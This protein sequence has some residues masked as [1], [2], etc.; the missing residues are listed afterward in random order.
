MAKAKVELMGCLTYTV[1]GRKFTRGQPQIITNAAEI[2]LFQQQP[3]FGVTMLDEPLKE[4]AAEVED[5]G[6]VTYS[7]DK[8]K[9]MTKPELLD[10]AAE[11]AVF[12]EGNE[13]K[14]KMID[15]ILKAQDEAKE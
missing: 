4:K 6:L 10:V 15:Q 3:E 7:E 2:K 9:S 5:P 8:L 1:G 13:K 11:L 12:L 14:S